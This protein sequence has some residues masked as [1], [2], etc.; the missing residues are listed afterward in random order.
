MP[1]FFVNQELETGLT[2]EIRGSD[3]HHISDVLRLKPGDW[4]ILSDSSGR[5][6]RT[7]ILN[8]EGRSIK[9]SVEAL[10]ERREG[11][12]PPA[13]AIA[14]IRSNE[15]AWAIQKCVELGCRHIIPFNSARTVRKIHHGDLS[16]KLTRL[17]K[18][19]VEAAKQSGLPLKPCV[20]TPVEFGELCNMFSDFSPTILLYEGEQKCDLR[21]VW[22]EYRLN[23]EASK[24]G[25]IVIGPEGGFTQDELRV[26]LSHGAIPASLGTQIL[27]AETA[28]VAAMAI[29]QY[30]LG[31]MDINKLEAKG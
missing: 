18:I 7:T 21:S 19:A 26:A 11:L 24:E 5:S 27:R 9:L 10:V 1:Q 12:E 28:A 6:F 13:L 22:K 25:L 2:I 15:L 8:S 17:C 3:A 14:S 20:D 31:N 4:L 23:D 16:R 30:E 29:C